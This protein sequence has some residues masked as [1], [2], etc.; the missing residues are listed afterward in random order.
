MAERDGYIP[1]VPCWIDTSQPDPE[2]AVAFY[3]GLFGWEFEDVTP[4]GSEGKYFIGRLRGGDVAAVASTPEAAPPT[5]TWI[6][7]IWVESA[8][9]TAS[10]VRDAGGKTLMEPCDVGEAGRMAVFA[11]AEGAAFCVWQ[12]KNHK[13]ARIVNEHGSLNFNNLNTREPEASMRFY[14]SV[15]GWQTLAM[16][17][18]AAAWTLPGYGDYLERGDPGLR[19]RMAAIGAPR[20]FEDVVATISP[21]REDQ[22]EAPAHWSVTF[23]VDDADASA[24]RAT[25]LGGTLLAAPFDAP[26]VRVAVIADPHGATFIASQ[27]VP[28][29]KDLAGRAETSV[30]AS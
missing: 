18:G 26:W 6:T 23:A 21:I 2:A 22:P 19:E 13:G 14:G 15:F 4:P 24:K 30:S 10:K 17:G 11:D 20:G 5:A 3:G 1:G 27:F 29:N 28:E 7:Y 9:E 25:E 12:A 16:G 8:D